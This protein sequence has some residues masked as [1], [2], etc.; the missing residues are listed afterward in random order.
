MTIQFRASTLTAI[1]RAFVSR[2]SVDNLFLYCRMNIGM[3][4]SD[5]RKQYNLR[6]AV[7]RCT[8]QAYPHSW[9]AVYVALDNAGMWT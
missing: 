2:V 4:T 8:V 3:L 9:T 6:D 5:S 7:S 1:M